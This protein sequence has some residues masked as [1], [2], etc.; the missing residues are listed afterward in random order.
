M[1]L[2]VPGIEIDIMCYNY[3]LLFVIMDSIFSYFNLK[4]DAINYEKIRVVESIFCN[5]MHK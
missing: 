5:L 4:R 1:V 3:G 2:L